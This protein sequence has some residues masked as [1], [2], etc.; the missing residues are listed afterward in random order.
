MFGSASAQE[1]CGSKG[2]CERGHAVSTPNKAWR[3]AIVG[4][5]FIHRSIVSL[6]ERSAVQAIG[7]ALGIKNPVGGPDHGLVIQAVSQP[8]ARS[9]V[10]VIRV[11]ARGVRGACHLE[12]PGQVAGAGVR[13]IQANPGLLVIPVHVRSVQVPTDAQV[14]GELAGHLEI[15]LGESSPVG[16]PRI[17]GHIFKVSLDFISPPQQKAGEGD[18][19]VADTAGRTL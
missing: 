12:R 7:V 19:G 8:E 18:A 13:H 2:R 3:Y 10:L 9:E 1:S 14:K 4:G 16:I 15:V 6:N 5:S 11:Q 17:T